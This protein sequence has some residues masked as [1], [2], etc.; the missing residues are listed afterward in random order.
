MPAP[1]SRQTK[2]PASPTAQSAAAKRLRDLERSRERT[3]KGS[4]IGEIP[5]V[6]NPARREACRNNLALALRTYF[7]ASCEWEFSPAHLRMISRDEEIAKSG[8]RN[9]RALPRGSGKTTIAENAAILEALYGRKRYIPIFGADK[10]AAESS[11]D[12]IKMELS[13]NDLLYEDFPEVC[14]AV[15]AL[16][17]K[18]Q[19]CASQAHN[20]KLTY[21]EW[22]QNSIVL[23]RIEGSAAGGAVICCY[24]LMAASRG[25]KRRTPEGKQIRPDHVILDDPQTD[26]SAGSV[27]QTRKRLSILR[28]GILKLAGHSKGFSIVCNATVIQ[29]GDMIEQLLADPSWQGERV[30]MVEKWSDR[31][32]DMWLGEYATIRRAFDKED[33]KAQLACHIRATQ[34]YAE[35]REAMDAGAVIYWPECYNRLP[36]D[37]GGELSAIQHAYNA[38]I[39]D[40]PEVF[41]SEYQQEPLEEA[42][43]SDSIAPADV[44]AAV[45]NVPQWIVPRGCETL[46]AFVDVQGALL[47]WMVVAWGHQLR[48]HVVAYGTYPDQGRAYFTLRE[49]KRTLQ[50]VLGIQDQSAAIYAGLEALHEELLG[51]QF[52]REDDDAI[53]QVALS[54]VDINWAQQQGTV[55]DFC[56]RSKWGPRVLPAKGR[57]VGAS[58]VKGIADAKPDRGERVG[59]NWRTS[60]IQ[61]QRHV[62]FDRNFWYSFVSGRI[63]LPE[64]DP[65]GL[66]L[67]AGD[68][69]LLADHLGGNKPVLTVSKERSV[70]EWKLIP[71]REDHWADG[72]VGAAVAA[73][74]TGLSAVGVES[75]PPRRE[76]RQVNVEEAQ[77]RMREQLLQ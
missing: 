55:L 27:V 5:P 1:K 32:E 35:R 64:G 63:K 47:Y 23:P 4:E 74:Y 49:A 26:E 10:R 7:P 73:S 45:R 70:N 16:E 69:S 6:K 39:D 31:H 68:H 77:K 41:A 19:R 33:P 75:G 11:I 12:A 65:Q 53:L 24:G 60:T 42:V 13:E 20:G 21:I 37:M 66:T 2:Q 30:K 15:R 71:G 9:L 25:M 46:T 51:R 44:S 57:F 22:T 29:R 8:G 61:R 3:R 62:L 18:P 38:L 76:R 54:L 72:I 28:K 59:A 50:D 67:H 17:N 43:E 36:V 58:S 14:H 48:G 52:A 56:R 34:F 40:G